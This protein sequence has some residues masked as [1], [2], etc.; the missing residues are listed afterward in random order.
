MVHEVAH[1]VLEQLGYRVVAAEGGQEAIDL[2]RKRG[3]EIDLVLLD[4][5]MPRMRGEKVFQR[6][7]EMNPQARIIISTGYPDLIERFPEL[8]QYAA[9]FA[10]KPYRVS[11]LGQA[12]EAALAK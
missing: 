5:M 2:Y 4:L 8:R 7:R 12:L 11:E 6:L 1:T 3:A 9:G 10:N